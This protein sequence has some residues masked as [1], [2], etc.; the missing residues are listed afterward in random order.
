MAVFAMPGRDMPQH[1]AELERWG[2]VVDPD[3]MIYQWYVNDIEG[4][5]APAGWHA[6]A[7]SAGPATSGCAAG[8]IS[9]TF[10]TIGSR[11]SCR[12]RDRSYADYILQDFAPGSAEWTEFERYFHAFATEA[13]ALRAAAGDAALSAGA[14]PRPLSAAAGAR[15]HEGAWRR[16]TCCRFRR[17]PGCDRAARCSRTRRRRGISRCS[18]PPASGAA[19]RDARIRVL[20]GHA[21]GG[22]DA[23]ATDGAADAARRSRRWRPSTQRRTRSSPSTPSVAAAERGLQT[24][25]VAADDSRHRM[26]AACASA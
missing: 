20:P 1:L 21:G 19:R 7:G 15:S 5:V 23:C 14:V 4:D 16:R 11:S 13:R 17:S 2:R 6:S 25:T 18:V 26:R 10:S 9:T 12:P 22:S 24:V 8:R 3:A